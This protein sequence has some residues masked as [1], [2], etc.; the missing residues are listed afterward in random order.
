LH[1]QDVTDL[2][3]GPQVQ[4]PFGLVGIGDFETPGVV[5]E[6]ATRIAVLQIKH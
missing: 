1:G 2:R 3:L 5:E 6:L 4:V